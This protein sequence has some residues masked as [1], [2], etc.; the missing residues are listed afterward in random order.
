ML[1]HFGEPVD[2]FVW[3]QEL[4]ENIEEPV[5]DLLVICL[6]FALWLVLIKR[7]VLLDLILASVHHRFLRILLGTRTI[8]ALILALLLKLSL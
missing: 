2:R 1:L 6:T 5:R 4:P 8:W 3:L 7:H